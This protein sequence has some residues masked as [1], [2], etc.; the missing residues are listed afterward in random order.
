M[1]DT[2]TA[3]EGDGDGHSVG[4]GVAE[5]EGK[6]WEEVKMEGTKEGFE[7]EGKR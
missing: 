5:G 3:V 2:E 7:K 4:G 1:D 6:E